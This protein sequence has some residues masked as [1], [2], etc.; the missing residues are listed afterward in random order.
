MPGLAD[1]PWELLQSGPRSQASKTRHLEAQRF[2]QQTGS[3][4]LLAQEELE[5]CLGEELHA[6]QER[7]A[8]EAMAF[9]ED[10]YGFYME[11]YE[12]I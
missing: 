1:T 12:F 6:L 10:L 5:A 4:M 9:S 3:E 2:L 11:L 7:N 8:G